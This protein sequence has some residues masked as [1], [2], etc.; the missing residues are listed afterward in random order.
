MGG[1]Q[2][3]R[4]AAV[5]QLPVARDIVGVIGDIGEVE[6]IAGGEA[7]EMGEL[8]GDASEIVP[9]AREDRFDLRRRFFRKRGGEIGPSGLVLGQ[10]RTEPAHQ[11]AHRVA[12]ADAV[13]AANGG[14]QRPHRE[15]G[16][17]MC[18]AIGLRGQETAQFAFHLRGGQN[19]TTTLPNT[20][21][22]ASR[23][24]PFSKSASGTAESMTGVMPFA[25]F[26]SDSRILR[27]VAPNE[28]MMRY[29]C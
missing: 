12:G 29:C 11:R 9:H 21:R 4:P 28:P 8:D 5:A 23:S 3:R 1:E 10:P 6:R 20:W 7:V 16:R 27:M 19:V 26:A 24:S 17:D 13:E 25:I 18:G 14:E 2:Q 15:L 22:L